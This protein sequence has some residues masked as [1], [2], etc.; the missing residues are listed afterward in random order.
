MKGS[1]PFRF[2]VA[3][4]THPSYKHVIN[5]AW[6]QGFIGVTKRHKMVQKVSLDFNSKVLGNIFGRKGK[7]E[8]QIDQI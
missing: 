4:T 1:R 8:Y 7:L 2:Q 5:K 6:N 3:W